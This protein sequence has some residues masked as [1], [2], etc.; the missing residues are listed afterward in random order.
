[1]ANREADDLA[2]KATGALQKSAEDLRDYEFEVHKAVAVAAEMKRKLELMKISLANDFVD[3]GVYSIKLEAGENLRLAEKF[4][5]GKHPDATTAQA[6]EVLRA[7]GLGDFVTERISQTLLRSHFKAL[8]AKFAKKN[9][10]GD[11]N[12]DGLPVELRGCFK[13]ST[14]STI[15]LTGGQKP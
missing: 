2:S 6:I 3:E 1:M 5:A 9:P 8:A 12:A 14:S 10:G 13:A 7:N 11:F 4:F 15:T